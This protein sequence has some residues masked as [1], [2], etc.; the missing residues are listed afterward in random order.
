MTRIFGLASVNEASAV[1]HYGEL[2]SARNI[3]TDLKKIMKLQV[4]SI[5]ELHFGSM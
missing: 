1:S 4:Y 2:C 3:G 5:K